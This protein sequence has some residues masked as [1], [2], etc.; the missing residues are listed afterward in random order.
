MKY[1][2]NSNLKHDNTN[3]SKGDIVEMSKEQ[4]E[5]LLKDGVLKN[6]NDTS[7]DEERTTPQAPV[8]V[9]NRKG[10]DIDGEAKVEPG[11][12]EKPQPGDETKD[13]GEDEGVTKLSY[14]VLKNVE[15]PRG[16]VHKVGAI[17]ELTAEEVDKFAEGLIEKIE[18]GEGEGNK[19][20]DNL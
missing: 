9:V 7:E 20:E 13:E 2:V 14:K 10:G 5:S 1:K 4:A 11:K 17:L 6:T 18:T 3:Y 16:T 15:Y 12:V 8:N 19:D